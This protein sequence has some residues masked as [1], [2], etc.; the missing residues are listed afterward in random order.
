MAVTADRRRLEALL[1]Q[2]EAEMR[3]KPGVA[4]HHLQRGILL[5][6]LLQPVEAIGCYERATDLDPQLA[7]AHCHRADLLRAFRRFDEAVAAY[8]NATAARPDYATAWNNKARALRALRRFGEA[9]Q[10]C[11]RAIAVEPAN[12]DAHLNRGNVLMEMDRPA[13]A[14]SAY[15]QAVSLKP[16]LAE[17]HFNAANAAARL[18]SPEQALNGYERALA[19]KPDFA[20]AYH[21]RGNA[22]EKLGRLAEALQSFEQAVALKPGLAESYNNKGNILKRLGRREEAAE[23]YMQAVRCRPGY[24]LA[25]SNRAGTLKDMGRFAEALEDCERALALVPDL[26]AAHFNR[27]NAL[28]GLKRFDE[29]NR[30]FDRALECAP[31]FAEARRNKAITTLLTGHL[32]EGWRLYEQR[33]TIAPPSRASRWTGEENLDGK[34]LLILA[35]QGFGDTIQFCRYASLAASCGAA[36]TLAVQDPLVELLASLHPAVGICALGAVPAVSDYYIPLMSMPH[37]FRTDIGSVPSTVPYLAAE[38]HRIGIWKARIGIEGFRVGI[39]WQ[40]TPGGDIDIGR[41]FPARHLEALAC[42]PGVRFISLQKNAGTE[43]LRQLSSGMKVEAFGDA[44]DPG[45]SAFLDTAAAMENLDLVISSD[46]AVAHLAGAL[47]RPVW[48]ALSHVPDWRWLMDRDDTPWYPTMKL[49]RQTQWNDWDGVFEAM[50]NT[51]RG[52]LRAGRRKP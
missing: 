36:V 35:E 20:E 17:A 12:A 8:E 16:D 47:G 41:S 43:Q 2:C 44:L 15:R 38:P 30:S 24:A 32:Q 26:A 9:L 31:D 33:E 11:D 4:A 39:S 40:G 50:K 34:T 37:A 22:F 19:L 1:A 25:W 23:S 5:Q 45:P 13:D 27:G 7:E 51:L 14:F 52:L 10:S 6:A 42:I 18:G 48:V 21:A 28:K 49:F 3:R 29:A 46:T